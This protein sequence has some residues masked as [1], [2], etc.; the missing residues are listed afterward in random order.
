MSKKEIM[1]E[2]RMESSF[3]ESVNTHLDL[4]K[5]VFINVVS[6]LTHGASGTQLILTASG[7]ETSAGVEAVLDLT[8][9]VHGL[10]AEEIF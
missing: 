2:T 8:I 7:Y 3:P 1:M 10:S 9:E 4:L 5:Q 6:S